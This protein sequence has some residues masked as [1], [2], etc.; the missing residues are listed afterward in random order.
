MELYRLKSRRTLRGVE[1]MNTSYL[2][3]ALGNYEVA[4]AMARNGMSV[5]NGNKRLS[6][7][8]R[9]IYLTGQLVLMEKLLNHANHYMSG[10]YETKQDEGISSKDEGLAKKIYDA[11]KAL[12]STACDVGWATQRV[13][14]NEL[15]EHYRDK[16]NAEDYD[17]IADLARIFHKAIL[18]LETIVI[19]LEILINHYK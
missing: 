5:C 10:F 17:V 4:F 13:A 18:A 8:D 11:Y 1:S 15:P 14:R 3:F 19:N 6:K 16:C 7:A 2:H 9:K 12:S